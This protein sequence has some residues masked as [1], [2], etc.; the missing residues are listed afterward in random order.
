VAVARRTLPLLYVATFA[1]FCA[2]GIFF[3][4]IPLYVHDELAGSKA[5]VGLAVGA[6]SISAVL[7]RPAVGRGIDRRGR[8]PFLLLAMAILVVSSLG[9]FLAHNIVAI[10]A[11]R[12]LQGIGGAAF[13]TTSAT[14]TTDVAPPERRASAIAALS[15][16]L[17]GGF[18]TGPAIGEW[19]I[20]HGGFGLAWRSIAMLGAA[21]L[22]AVVL[23]PETGRGI[24]AVRAELGPSKRTLLH[25][26]A[27]APGL[28]L[29]S[30]AVGYTS[31]TA[32]SSLY[33]REIG[34]R[35][36]GLLYFVFAVSII[37]VRLLVIGGMSDRRGHTVV[38]IPGVAVAGVGLTVMALLHHPVTASLGVAGFGVGFALVFP[39]LMAFTVDRVD[40]HER[41]EVLG[42][43]TAFMDIGS[44]GGGFLVGYIADRAGFRWG[45]GVPALLCLC[46]L[47]LLTL[48]ARREPVRSDAR[49]D[50][51]S[52]EP[53]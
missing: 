50:D 5:S 47:A 11:I 41:G 14:V 52:F 34:L 48:I 40:D 8:R 15:L 29:M 17:Y 27:V 1:N 49:R 2:L 19:L 46:G 7:L 35:S 43:F 23:L 51:V 20:D 28:V 3:V 6:F 38:A 22:G 9:F 44:G 33:A 36:S 53:G 39:S 32:F 21:G 13:Y 16:F 24:M 45:F 10:V 25:P 12:L 4:A 30:T 37:A 42:S 18:A 26:A 31:I